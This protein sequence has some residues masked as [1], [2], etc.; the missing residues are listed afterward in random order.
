LQCG[1]DAGECE[2]PVW[3]GRAQPFHA[4]KSG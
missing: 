1:L 4:A 3:L 2:V